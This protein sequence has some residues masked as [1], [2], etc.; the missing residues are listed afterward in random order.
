MDDSYEKRRAAMEKANEP[1]LRGFHEYLINRRTGKKASLDHL[2]RISFFADPFLM[3]YRGTTLVDGFD[4]AVSFLG[5]FFIRKAMWSDEKSM[6][7]N[8]DSF[9]KF[10]DFLLSTGRIDG[11]KYREL[12]KEL[13][14]QT[15][16]LVRLVNRYNNPRIELEDVW[17]F[18]DDE[19]AAGSP[20]AEEGAHFV[21]MLSGRAAKYFG[22]GMAKL[23]KV[24]QLEEEGHWTS[25]WRCE[26]I[27][28]AEG[29]RMHYF[30][31]TNARS[32]YSV[33]VP[34]IDGRIESMV[35][36]FSQVM[37]FRC[38]A[39][40]VP[41]LA[42]GGATFSLVR[43]QPR[44]LIGSQKELVRFAYHLMSDGDF[45][46]ERIHGRLNRMPMSAIREVFPDDAFQQRMLADP[47]GK[48]VPFPG[49]DPN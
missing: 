46:F 7:E 25:C 30:L 41:S 33:V 48:I 11:E 28:P 9:G 36:T 10:Y 17:D 32:L 16:R 3:E 8:V 12:M 39:M 15:P 42:S 24:D 47:P 49:P 27:A 43:G 5:D 40:G 18:T 31:L 35:S 37:E 13:E 23:P 38:Q 22:E 45:N 21:I 34:C 19:D 14:R 6:R 4:D 26:S 44:S 2:N 29:G 1:V 20:E